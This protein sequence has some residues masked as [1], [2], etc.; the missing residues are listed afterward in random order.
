M[1]YNSTNNEYLVVWHGDDNTAPLVDNEFEIYGQ[2]FA[3]LTVLSIDRTLATPQCAETSG[4]LWQVTFSEAVSGVTT[5]NF[6]LVNPGGG[7]S[8]FMLTGVTPAGP[9]PIATWTV[10]ANVGSGSGTLRLDLVNSSGIIPPVAVPFTSGQTYTIDLAPPVNAGPNQTVCAGS[11]AVTLA[12]TI[13]G[14]ASNGTWS[15]G[16][17]SFAPNNTT[18]NAVYTPSPGEVSAGSVTLTLTTNDPPGACGAVSDTVTIFFPDCSSILLV[19]DTSNH[20]IQRFDG[21]TWTV[22]G[23]GTVGSGAGQFRLPE[24]V[25]LD[26]NDRM[27]V[28]DTGNNRIQWSTDNGTTWANFAVIGSGLNQVRAPQGVALDSAG[29]LYVSDTGNGR[30]LRFA[31]GVPGLA[32]VLATNGV[33]SGQVASPRGLIVDS[34]FRLFVC[35]T[36]N[37][38][39]LRIANANTTVSGTSGVAIATAGSALNKVNAPQGITIDGN[40]DL[41]VADTGNNRILKWRNANPTVAG[42]SAMALTG[43]GLGQVS[44]AE[45]VTVTQF[46]AGPYVGG[47]M[48]IVGDTGNNRIEGRFIPTG[49]WTLIG[50]PNGLGTGVGQF[51]APSKIR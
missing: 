44:A 16:A 27:Y 33:A 29:N 23:V 42:S 49:S 1:A 32:T 26:G 46:V 35:D 19:A 34:T 36:G 22:I 37:S 11:P 18:L 13:G 30:V 43:S 5:S 24:A 15:G 21:T 14:S 31:G 51:R 40:G 41:Y 12:G 25:T 10:A 45:G 38:R 9:E 4:I 39:V 3:P 48:L 6:Q 8:G 50:A 28:A 47:P 17:G 20:R 2:Q 7:L